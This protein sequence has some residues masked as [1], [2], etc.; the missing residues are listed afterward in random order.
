MWSYHFRNIKQEILHT[1][2]LM[3]TGHPFLKKKESTSRPWPF[4]GGL[5]DSLVF[6]Q[7]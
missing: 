7:M 4:L 2:T 5:K 3:E 1:D 6:D